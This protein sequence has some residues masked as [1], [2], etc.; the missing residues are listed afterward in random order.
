MSK[1]NDIIRV[2]ISGQSRGEIA[3]KE[4]LLDA[5][6]KS[7]HISEELRRVLIKAAMS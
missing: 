2:A 3:A 7:K 6:F 5:A 4:I 1:Q